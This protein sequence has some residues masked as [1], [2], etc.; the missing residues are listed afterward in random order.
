PELPVNNKEFPGSPANLNYWQLLFS[1]RQELLKGGHILLEALPEVISALNSPVRVIFA[2]DGRERER[3][4]R[5]ATSL[6]K[7][8][9]NLEIEFSGWLNRDQMEALFMRSDLLVVPSLWPEPFGLVGPEAG[10]RG[11]PVAAFNV[12]GIP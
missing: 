10:L 2:G 12:G 6:Q 8:Y 11:V 3:L 7:S 9:P 5:Q 4:Q 1:G